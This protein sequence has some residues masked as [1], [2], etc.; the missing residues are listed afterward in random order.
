MPRPGSKPTLRTGRNAV[1]GLLLAA[2]WG[3]LTPAKADFRVPPY[4]QNPAP[5]AITLSWL[6]DG[7]DPGTVYLRGNADSAETPARRFQATAVAAG[8]LDYHQA[9]RERAGAAALRELPYLQ[10]TRLEGL[11]PGHRYQYVV[12]Q[13]EDQ[14]SGSFRTPEDGARPLRFVVFGDSETEPESTGKPA[15]WPA[16]GAEDSDRVYLVDQTTGYRANLAIMRSREPDFVAI[17]GDL[18]ESGGEQRDWDEFWRQTSDLAAN[19]FVL[20]ALGNHEY[21]GGPGGLGRYRTID[22]ERAVAKYLTYFDLP[23]NGAARAAHHER[24]YRVDWGAVTLVVL[25][26]NNAYPNR[27]RSDP[28]WF[29]LGRREGGMAPDWQ[30]GSEQYR[31]LERTLAES[32]ARSAFTFVMFHHCPYSSGVHG[33]PPGDGAGKDTLSGIPLRQLTPLFLR[34]GVDVLLTG[35]DEMFEHS[36]IR[37]AHDL[38]VFDVGVGGDGLRGPVAAAHNPARVFLAHD[39]APEQWSRDDRLLDGGKHYGHLEVNVAPQADGSWTARLEM[40]Y[41]FPLTGAEGQI[42]GF[43]RRV[44]ADPIILT[45][46][47]GK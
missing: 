32:Q 47:P 7:A 14:A 23:G 46:A 37:G 18:V 44:Y 43:E 3:A 41:A 42:T 21:F 5:T 30:H 9:E 19:A 27:G 24:Y 26:L 1:R 11:Q 20:P 22:S 38:H 13:G 31:W 45:S 35:H 29:L 6:S 36:V 28:N 40:V 2:A 12:Q 4:L 17:A 16:P 39:D 8:A 33:Q 10:Q 15:R 25:D 34:Y